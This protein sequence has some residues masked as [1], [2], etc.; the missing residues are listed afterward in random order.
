[1]FDGFSIAFASQP[2]DLYLMDKNLSPTSL[3][4]TT[5]MTGMTEL[6]L[7][8]DT[9]TEL[10]N[11][12]QQH[13]LGSYEH[14]IDPATLS[15]PALG[16]EPLAL[17]LRA[18]RRRS[19][20]LLVWQQRQTMSRRRCTP[21]HMS[22]ASRLVE[23]L[24]LD[25]NPPYSSTHPCSQYSGPVSPTSNPS[26][27]NSFDSTPSSSASGD[28]GCD[29]VSWSKRLVANKVSKESRRGGT[30][31]TLETRQQRLVLKQVRMRK[32]FVS[33]RTAA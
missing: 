2:H 24:S 5:R 12:F 19:S 18:A 7:K 21:A 13:R 29:H 31:D 11:R 26:S 33:L 27:F 16:I 22:Q 1:M 3:R 30:V 25:V 28:P 6:W 14:E 9:V 32:S 15:P 23:E 4:A 20:S 10:S 17:P 8:V